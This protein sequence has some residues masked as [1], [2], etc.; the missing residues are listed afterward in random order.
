MSRLVKPRKQCSPSMT[1][2]KISVSGQRIKTGARPSG[3]IFLPCRHPI[4]IVFGFSGIIHDG[5]RRQIAGI[6][7]HR[8]FLI[9]EQVSDPLAQGTHS[10]RV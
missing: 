8:H 9:T 7:Q 5:Q 2:R 10:M 3:G 6:G 4:Q 1:A